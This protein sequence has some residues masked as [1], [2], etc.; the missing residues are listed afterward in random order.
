MLTAHSKHTGLSNHMERLIRRQS[1]GKTD[2]LPFEVWP[3]LCIHRSHGH[4]VVHRA[5]AV[6][7]LPDLTS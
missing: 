6:E 3:E 5:V 4:A 2:E 1:Y 7:Y